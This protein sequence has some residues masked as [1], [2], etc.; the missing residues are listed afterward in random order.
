MTLNIFDHGFVSFFRDRHKRHNLNISGITWT[1]SQDSSVASR[2]AGIRGRGEIDALGARWPRLRP[3]FLS[4]YPV[5]W[6]SNVA[7]RQLPRLIVRT[8]PEPEPELSG[9]GSVKYLGLL[10]PVLRA[11]ISV[12]GAFIQKRYVT[13]QTK[14]H[15]HVFTNI[16]KEFSLKIE[17]YEYFAIW[18]TFK[19]EKICL[20][21]YLYKFFALFFLLPMSNWSKSFS[22]V[23][24]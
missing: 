6:L 19:Q 13:K 12:T 22:R 1:T 8:E 16:P 4:Y 10:G 9:Q 18:E 24:H 15:E 23:G 7:I 11:P 20:C 3:P 5:I 2:M 17:N 14:R 21:V